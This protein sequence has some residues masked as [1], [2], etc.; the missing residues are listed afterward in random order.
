MKQPGLFPAIEPHRHLELP[1]DSQHVLYVEECGNPAGQPILF[2]H[3]GP[4]G[5]CDEKCRRFFDPEKWRI[6]L[7]DQRGCG[8]SK[9]F[10]EI[11]ANT[12]PDLVSDIELI[13]E[14]LDIDRWALFGGSW[15]STLSLI[16]AE[17][18]P[19]RITGMVM[20]GIFLARPADF[21]WVYYSGAPQVF[22][23][24]YADFLKPVPAD[25]L[26]NLLQAYHDLLNDSDPKVRDRASKSWTAWEARCSTL[27]P[28]D[29]ILKRF[30]KTETAVP[31]A[32]LETHYFVHDCFLG[33]NQILNEIGRIRD[34][35]AHIVQGRYDMVCPPSAAWALHAAWPGADFHWVQNAGHSAFEPGIA[36]G[37][38]AATD[39]LFQRVS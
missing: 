22:P 7:F 18:F 9:P 23:D 20:S 16:Y 15:G 32:R 2:V 36:G 6:I 25:Q 35:P 39:A 34:L 28:D 38:I 8:R 24:H 12:T 37:L 14:H 4:G 27:L 21:D 19:D 26:G 29:E 17:A 30:D 10:A 13:R 5:G 33:P 31:M 3:G 11:R 1:V